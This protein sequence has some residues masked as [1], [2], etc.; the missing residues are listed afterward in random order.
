MLQLSPKMATILTSQPETGMGYQITRVT[1]GDGR[2]FD[3]VVIVGGLITKIGESA[4]I[5]FR[6]DEIAAIVVLAR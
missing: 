3:R 5:P 4:E 6:E 1:L 2:E